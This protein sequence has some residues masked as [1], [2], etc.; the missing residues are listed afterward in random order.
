M[1]RLTMQLSKEQSAVV[2]HGPD[3][4]CVI[5]CAG[6]GK[7]RTAVRLL[8]E[9]RRR[10][11]GQRG[12]IALLSFSNVAVNTF[13]RDYRDLGSAVGLLPHVEIDTVDGFLTSNI[14]R[15][16]THRTMKAP[17][18]A[19]LVTGTE[20]FLNSFTVFDPQ[21]KRSYPTASMRAK[22]KAGQFEFAAGETYAPIAIPSGN[23]I[24]AINKLGKLGAYS[25]DLGRYWA[26]RSLKEQP[27]LAKVL[28]RRYSHILVDEAQDIG[29][30]HEAILEILVAAG[31]KLSLGGDPHQSIYEFA[32]ADGKFLSEYGKREGVAAKN[33]TRNYR[34][35]PLILNVANKLSGR[36]DCHDREPHAHLSGAY[37]LPYKAGDNDA[38]LAAFRNMARDSK[39]EAQ[40]CAILCRGSGRVRE[41]G[42]GADS[43]GQG[44]VKAFAR[45][46]IFR[47]K[48][49]RYDEA[50]HVTVS[51]VVRLLAPTHGDL[52]SRL[53][54]NGGEAG[55]SGIRRAIWRFTRDAATGL[56]AGSLLADTQWHPALVAAVKT[57]LAS[58]ESEFGLKTGENVG[59]KLKK[60]GLGNQPLF[61]QPD[62]AMEDNAPIRICTVHQAKG[63]SIDAVMYVADKAHIRAMLDGPTTENGR[64]GYVAVT[65]ARNLFVLAVP[66]SCLKEFEPGLQACGF[67]RAGTA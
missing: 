24:A 56:P 9:M 60:T 19:F 12:R 50:F 61:A 40:A 47:D 33:L 51:A 2:D 29:P 6:S 22:L 35:V 34:S 46:A 48:H 43:P 15:P 53:R 65:R 39:A 38:L 44:T 49:Q 16:H 45:A 62:L 26:Y 8:A 42:G 14:L 63:E 21:T 31:T 54:R 28:A 17:G 11:D 20:P 1:Q 27:F 37:Y 23:A 10:L 41:L 32:D 36:S 67:L 57:L 66:E 30:E 55:Y 59:N 64:I 52:A 58:L 7:T 13:Q 25:H 4:L 5:A 3:P 18:N